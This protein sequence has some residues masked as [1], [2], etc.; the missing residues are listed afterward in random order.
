M[1]EPLATQQ[2][3]IAWYNILGQWKAAVEKFNQVVA[4]L[5]SQEAVARKDPVLYREYQSKLSTASTLQ[6]K[7][8]E[9]TNATRSAIDWFKNVFG[10]NGMGELGLVPLI[11]IAIVAAAIGAITK[12]VSDAWI[13]SAKLD[14]VAQLERQGMPT[15]QAVTAVQK[16]NAPRSILGFDPKWLVI[17]G[18]ALM[19][20]PI[21]VPAIKKAMN[22]NGG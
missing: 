2:D 21:V 9:I 17:G 7:I 18:V 15:S 16:L 20:L 5:R 14:K 1:A 13:F 19:I 10:F 4:K 22:K 11:P 8:T 6:A 3:E 12:F